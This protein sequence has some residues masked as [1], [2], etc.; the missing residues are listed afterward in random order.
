MFN[1]VTERE[2][3][4][5]NNYSKNDLMKILKRDEVLT[6][7]S[8]ETIAMII[9]SAIEHHEN[10]SDEEWQNLSLEL[11]CS[12]ISRK[13]VVEMV[14]IFYPINEFEKTVLDRIRRLIT[15]HYDMDDVLFNN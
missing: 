7:C 11:S 6:D 1:L 5:N 8:I 3:E 9:A 10:V 14:D 15:I 12:N 4:M 2:G 13:R